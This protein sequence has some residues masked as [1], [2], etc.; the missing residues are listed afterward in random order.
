MFSKAN[1]ALDAAMNP[2]ST[3]PEGRPDEGLL[4]H[5]QIAFPGGL[6]N[7]AG[8]YSTTAKHLAANRSYLRG[9][10]ARKPANPNGRCA[11]VTFPTVRGVYEIYF[12]EYVNAG[13]CRCTAR[14]RCTMSVRA[15]QRKTIQ[16]FISD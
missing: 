4:K 8:R 12:T 14:F 5:Y 16:E 1:E 6:N 2:V 7:P 3:I 9:G 11:K 15:W 13:C 10:E